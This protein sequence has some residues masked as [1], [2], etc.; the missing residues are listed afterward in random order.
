MTL[1]IVLY[2]FV[3]LLVA[4]RFPSDLVIESGDLIKINSSEMRD[5]ESEVLEDSEPMETM[6]VT[7]M[8]EILIT[9]I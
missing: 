7:E 9:R 5:L 6:E 2:L 4:E 3:T 8:G 1:Y